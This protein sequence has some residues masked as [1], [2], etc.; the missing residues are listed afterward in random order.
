MGMVC[1]TSMTGIRT[2]SAFLLVAA[3][4]PTAMLN[5]MDRSSAANI[6]P[7]E[8]RRSTDELCRRVNPCFI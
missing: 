4:T 7:Q 1:R 5:T 2:L 8:A 3:V 6:L